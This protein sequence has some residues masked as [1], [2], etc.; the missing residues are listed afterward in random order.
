MTA[1]PR[2]VTRLID[3]EP[4]MEGAGVKLKRLIAGRQ[5]DW[6]DPFLLLDHFGSEEPADYIAGFPMHPHRG[7]ETVTYMLDGETDHRDTMGNAGTI[8]PGAVQW[9]SAGGGLLHEEMPRPVKGRLEGFQLWVN[10]PA[11]LK[12]SRPNYQEFTAEQIPEARREDGTVIRVVAGETDGVRGA[13][14]E[15][16]MRPTYLDVHLAPGASFVQ[17]VPEG[18]AAFAYAYRGGGTFGIGADGK[19]T[20]LQAPRLAIL[21]DG[22]SVE[23]RA[24]ADG[25][26]FLLVSGQPTREAIARYGPFVMNTRAEIMQ[27]VN[28]LNNGTFVWQEG[29]RA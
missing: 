26:R 29:K 18:H 21:G 28:D 17:P 10:L 24:G 27:A 23:V 14:T 12:M 7:I 15:I 25:A 11:K 8:G 9:M 22:G 19:G 1:N 6:I 3:P 5:I 13:V 2:T 16:A 20:A 4:T